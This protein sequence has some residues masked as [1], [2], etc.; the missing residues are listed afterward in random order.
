VGGQLR[1]NHMIVHSQMQELDGS[2]LIYRGFIYRSGL[3]WSMNRATELRFITQWD[4][5]ASRLLMQ[6]VLTIRPNAFTLLYAGGQ[7]V[8]GLWQAY[9]KGQVALGS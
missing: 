9:L 7:Y 6:P 8:K 4:D 1:W 3:E 2:A 5:F